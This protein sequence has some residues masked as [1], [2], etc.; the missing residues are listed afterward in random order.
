MFVCLESLTL[1]FTC[2]FLAYFKFHSDWGRV[3]GKIKQNEVDCRDT[4]PLR[5][6]TKYKVSVQFLIYYY[7]S[8]FVW[9]VTEAFM[10]VTSAGHA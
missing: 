9:I 7:F 8:A 10:V 4:A 5:T 2:N 3:I 6:V 1:S